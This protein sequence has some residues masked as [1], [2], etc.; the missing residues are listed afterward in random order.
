V[1]DASD[2][3]TVAVVFRPINRFSLR[4]KVGKNVVRVIF[5]DVIVDMAPLGATFG[6]RLNVNIRHVVLPLPKYL[7]MHRS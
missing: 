7:C 2:V 3:G 1:P 5:D 4:L 6:T